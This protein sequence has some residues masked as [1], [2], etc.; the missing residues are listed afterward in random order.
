MADKGKL[1][2]EIEAL[3]AAATGLH[4]RHQFIDGFTYPEGINIAVNFT[5]DFDTMLLR[6]L[7][8]E[9]TMQKA[10]GVLARELGYDRNALPHWKMQAVPIRQ[11]GYW[12]V[13]IYPRPTQPA[14]DYAYESGEERLKRNLQ[15]L[16]ADEFAAR[17]GW[18]GDLEGQADDGFGCVSGSCGIQGTWEGDDDGGADDGFGAP[19]GGGDLS[20]N[21]LKATR[22]RNAQSLSDLVGGAAG[23]IDPTAG[24]QR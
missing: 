20:N 13:R 21:A 15:R 22:V 24:F 5:A 23:L 10:R 3:E 11:R 2:A 6:R 9:P 17:G 19:F 1:N 16:I 12:S 4:A 7:L 18:E 14:I 8:N